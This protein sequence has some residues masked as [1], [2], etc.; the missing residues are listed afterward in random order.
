MELNKIN[1]LVE[2]FFLKKYKEKKILKNQP[3]LKWLKIMIKMIF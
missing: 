1:S 3:F 2:L